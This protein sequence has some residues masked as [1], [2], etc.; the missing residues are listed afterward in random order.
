MERPEARAPGGL[1]MFADVQTQITYIQRLLVSKDYTMYIH[2]NC[3]VFKEYPYSIVH[4]TL[5]DLISSV[6]FIKNAR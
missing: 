1:K 5:M 2:I 6:F 4:Y 3:A